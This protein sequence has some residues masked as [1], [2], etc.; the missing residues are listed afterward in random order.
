MKIS[1]AFK[2]IYSPKDG[3][4]LRQVQYMYAYKSLTIMTFFSCSKTAVLSMRRSSW[5]LQRLILRDI[6]RG[7]AESLLDISTGPAIARNFSTFLW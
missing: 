1:E 3:C 2:Q 6:S 4:A 5:Y 7:G